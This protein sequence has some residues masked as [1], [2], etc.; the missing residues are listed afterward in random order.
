MSKSNVNEIIALLWLLCFYASGK[1][2]LFLVF[3]LLG[4]A[5]SLIYAIKGE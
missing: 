5:S 4:I 3:C 2:V 1:E